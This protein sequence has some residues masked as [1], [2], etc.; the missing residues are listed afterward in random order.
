[1]APEA[2]AEEESV[3]PKLLSAP[4]SVFDVGVSAQQL[5]PSPADAMLVGGTFGSH[6]CS[7]SEPFLLLLLPLTLLLLLRFVW[8]QN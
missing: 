7:W 8:W 3:L 1:L 5:L 2:I 6:D 4:W